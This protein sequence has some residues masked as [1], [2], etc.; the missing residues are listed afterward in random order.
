MTYVPEQ[1]VQ[2]W[3]RHTTAASG[4]FES[5]CCVTEEDEDAVYTIV[6]RTIN[7]QSV[8]YVERLH[9]RRVEALED[10]FFVDAGLSYSGA[11][12]TTFGGL[13]HLEGEEVNI[14]ADGAVMSRQVVTGGEVTLQQPASTVHVGLP[15]TA[16]LVTL[17]MAF[18]AQ[19]AGQ[20]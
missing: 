19:A 8:R 7:G 10:A 15:I 11:P 18:E 1:Q 13:D 4:K 9:S 20:G 14:L 12:A 2:G 16:D 3:H 17:P 5:V 6:K